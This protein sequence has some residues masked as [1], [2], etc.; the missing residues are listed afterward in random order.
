MGLRDIVK[1]SHVISLP[2][3]IGQILSWACR[4]FLR[5]GGNPRTVRITVLSYR[6][7]WY[8]NVYDRMNIK[9][10]GNRLRVRRVIDVATRKMLQV[11]V[12]E[13]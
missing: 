5:C 13:K 10:T 12:K 7:R 6:R 9:D 8:T 1:R 4:K 3:S 2:V 11:T